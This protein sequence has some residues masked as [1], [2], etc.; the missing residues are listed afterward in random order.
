MPLDLN[1]ITN[2]EFNNIILHKGLMTNSK[3]TILK[4]HDV[5]GPQLG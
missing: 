2:M 3:S 4:P 1:L 5:F